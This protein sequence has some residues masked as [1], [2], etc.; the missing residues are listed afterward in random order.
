MEDKRGAVIGWEESQMGCGMGSA[1]CLGL[2]GPAIQPICSVL[3]QDLHIQHGYTATSN[4]RLSLSGLQ[5]HTTLPLHLQQP[6]P[7]ASILLPQ[8]GGSHSVELVGLHPLP[9]CVSRLA[10]GGEG[11]GGR[12][13]Q[14][15][16]VQQMWILAEYSTKQW[17]GEGE[18]AR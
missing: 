11:G 17:V 12:R 9:G 13:R 3:P 8:P 5:H 18:S 4:S 6:S 1:G 14:E 2:S 10:L 7:S 16:C 15:G